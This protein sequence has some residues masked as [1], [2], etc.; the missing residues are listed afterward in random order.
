MAQEPGQLTPES[1]ELNRT[2]FE[3]LAT[4][5]SD[6]FAAESSD[7]NLKA[8]TGNDETE[9]LKSQ[10]EETRNQMGETIDA[11]QERLSFSNLSEQVS[12]HVNNAIE[13]AKNSVYDATIGKAVGFMKN[14]GDGIGDTKFVRTARN[15]PLP[16]VL[17]GLGAGLLAYN[18]YYGSGGRRRSSRLREGTSYDEFGDRDRA[19]YDME[20]GTSFDLGRHKDSSTMSKLSDK[21]SNLTGSVSNAAS[22][23]LESAATA[24]N[25]AYES[26]SNTMN[27]A[28]T[29][30]RDIA[31]R[32]YEKAGE[33]RSVAYES[34]DHHINE[35]PLAVGAAAFALGAVV[36]LAIP[37]TRYEGELLGETRDELLRKAQDKG[38]ML[39]DKTRHVVDEAANVVSK[40]SRSIVH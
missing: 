1:G 36:G 32:A 5:R 34:Y 22:S 19:R 9:H 30:A 24:A 33:Y 20:R 8:D 7:A 37:S 29:N 3:S 4:G 25:S 23:A 16:L 17:I 39:L 21:A 10:I 13:T 40:E 27:S 35:N 11:L 18:S 2:E 31:N 6:D 14:M 26:A 12:E 15:N 38:S 28:V